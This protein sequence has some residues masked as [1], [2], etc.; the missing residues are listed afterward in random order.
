MRP[1]TINLASL[2]VFV[3][4]ASAPPGPATSLHGVVLLDGET[5]SDAVV[6]LLSDNSASGTIP[7]DTFTMDQRGLRFLPRVLPVPVGSVID[8]TN[9]DPVLHNVFITSGDSLGIDL[10]T[11][12]NT[13]SRAHS[14]DS[15]GT[16]AILCQLH[17]EMTAWVVVVPT[18][19]YQMTDAHGE[20]HLDGVPAAAYTLMVW[21]ERAGPYE[22]R[23]QLGSRGTARMTIRLTNR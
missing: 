5:A 14:F 16:Y 20:F 6:Y 22:Q 17:P 12:P 13:E 8:F 19:Y 21:H 2:L 1:S 4:A 7:A 3:L 10:G 15:P 18:T 11:Y 9:S 23:V